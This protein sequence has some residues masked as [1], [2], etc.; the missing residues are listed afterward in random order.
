MLVQPLN[1]ANRYKVMSDPS[2]RTVDRWFG[3]VT[4][5]TFCAAGVNDGSCAYGVPALGEFGSAG[6][7]TERAPG[8]FNLDTS[9]GKRFNVTERQR[10]EF[11]AEMFNIL[12][13][14][15]LGAPGRDITTPAAFGA[16]GGQINQPR[17]IQ[18][19]LKYQF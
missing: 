19:G 17:N 15:S 6:V 1:R 9:I 2:T 12:N 7:G 5:S 14:V 11:R 4:G 16:I 3:D 8:F 10:L 13:F 18:F